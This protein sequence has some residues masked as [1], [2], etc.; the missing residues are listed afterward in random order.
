MA[1]T[2]NGAYINGLDQ[3]TTLENTLA[4][5]PGSTTTDYIIFSLTVPSDS[6]ADI[7]YGIA[8]P[9]LAT[10]GG[11]LPSVSELIGAVVEAGVS[12][13]TCQRVWLSIGGAD[14]STF[15]NMNAI[16]TGSD[17][18]LKQTL[19]SNFVALRHVVSDIQGVSSVGFDLD[20]E[21]G[22]GALTSVVATVTT[23]LYKATNA[24]FT[25]CPFQYG[26]EGK[27]I[28]AL[29]EVYTNLQTQ[30]VVGMNLQVYAGGTPN[31]PSA[32][33]SALG[34]KLAGTGLTSAAG[35]IWPIQ[36]MDATYTPEQMTE[37][38]KT[39]G[40]Q[41]GSFWATAALPPANE[42]N[43]GDNWAAYAAAI[44]AAVG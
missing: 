6:S 12:K 4:L 14:T 2:M 23:E 21:E 10:G 25:F 27:W 37:N 8:G 28:D 42:S 20:Y 7:Q 29:G 38:L 36:S 5:I 44:A 19:L 40:S 22:V 17:E 31:N 41:G 26:C 34:E 13:G 9:I 3:P 16:L 24:E 1:I 18:T 39:W 11:A 15:T 30:P 35:F 43:P 32:W 33:T